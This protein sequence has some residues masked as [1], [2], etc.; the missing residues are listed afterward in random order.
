MM[1]SILQATMIHC[2]GNVSHWQVAWP[3][4]YARMRVRFGC[5]P[6]TYVRPDVHK[7]LSSVRTPL[8]QEST[9]LGQISASCCESA[10]STMQ[11]TR[12]GL[13]F[14]LDSNPGVTQTRARV[15]A[16]QTR[17]IVMPA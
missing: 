16:L 9:S 6:I 3:R 8:E 5:V 2:M 11:M 7:P 4:P 1:L 17:I 14:E 12:T 13:P 15:T 10:N